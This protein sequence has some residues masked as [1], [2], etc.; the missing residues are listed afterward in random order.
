MIDIISSWFAVAGANKGCF[1]K[2]K[3]VVFTCVMA[4]DF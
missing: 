3:I 4:F 1:E 2:I